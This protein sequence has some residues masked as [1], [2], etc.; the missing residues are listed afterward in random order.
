MTLFLSCHFVSLYPV[1]DLS[2]PFICKREVE[3]VSWN[4]SCLKSLSWDLIGCCIVLRGTGPTDRR[5][6]R[7]SAKGPAL[8]VKKV[9]CCLGD[10]IQ[11]L[12]S[13]FGVSVVFHANQERDLLL[14]TGKVCQ[15]VLENAKRIMQHFRCLNFLRMLQYRRRVDWDLS[16]SHFPQLCIKSE[17]V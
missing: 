17:A 16:L 10:R 12:K 15:S 8:D 11:R 14:S 13:W 3:K 1:F 7:D 2:C 6:P 5:P 9:W 4:R